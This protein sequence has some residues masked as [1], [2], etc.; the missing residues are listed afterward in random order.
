MIEASHT[1]GKR[2]IAF[3]LTIVVLLIFIVGQGSVWTWF[4]FTQRDYNNDVMYEKMV[5]TA[6]VISAAASQH[7]ARSDWDGLNSLL[8]GAFVGGDVLYVKVFDR[9]GNIVAEKT[10]SI[11]TNDTSANPLYVPWVSTYIEIIMV[12][13]NPAGN[14]EIAVSGRAA[15]KYMLSLLT[16]HPLVEGVVL[17]LVVIGIFVYL[18]RS[19]GRPLGVLQD[20]IG[21]ITSGDLTVDIPS[22]GANEIGVIADGLRFLVETLRSNITNIN[23]TA[24][25]AAK[26]TRELSEMFSV[27][28]ESGRRQS[29]ATSKI[30]ETLHNSSETQNEIARATE[31][32]ADFSSDNVSFLLE[33]KSTADEIVSSSNKLYEASEN[34]YSIVE[35]MSQTSRTMFHNSQEMLSSVEET[36][37]SIEEISASVKEVERSARESSSVAEDVRVKA[38][39]EGTLVVADAIEGIDELSSTV[40]GAVDKVRRLGKRSTDVQKML[41]VIRDVTEQTN[42]LSLNAAILAEQAGEYGKGFAVVADEMRAL[43]DRTATSTKDISGTIGKIQ[44]E[45]QEV[46]TSIEEGQKLVVQD[47]K[48]VYKV[49]ESMGSI[50]EAA[51]KSARM[52]LAIESVTEEQSIALGLVTSSIGDISTMA[53]KMSEAMDEQQKGSSYLL[54][55]V[56]EVKEIAEITKRST[57]EQAGGTGHM[58]KN[59]EM[60]SAKISNISFSAQSQQQL[61]ESMVVAVDDISKLA[62]S[63]MQHVDDM[64]RSLGKLTDQTSLLSREMGSFRVSSDE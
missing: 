1:K 13:G 5:V 20:R 37:A 24:R 49:G 33:V 34:S 40:A 36:L 30:A 17:F 60:A 46:V 62:S 11:Q 35:E 16:V 31:Q 47:S 56:G 43:S 27:V 54:E 6:R 38:V 41:S 57:D 59:I 51:S 44:A 48:L 9:D 64:V 26:A 8:D 53:S 14:V 45:I 28:A 29:Q 19:V 50:L 63:T 52:A 7:I 12:D 3:S 15:N 61:H 39:E 10:Y 25:N 32:L 23:A 42:L 58:S 18:N 22:S 2:S 55:R 4:L 21:D